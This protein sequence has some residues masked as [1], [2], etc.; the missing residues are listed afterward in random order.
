MNRKIFLGPSY[1][2]ERAFVPISTSEGGGLVAV[3]E[4]CRS[5]GFEHEGPEFV[6]YQRNHVAN[7]VLPFCGKC[8]R[9]LYHVPYGP[10]RSEL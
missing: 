9:R 3:L 5:C 7:K 6:Y 10:G 4:K 2:L 1:C 8:S